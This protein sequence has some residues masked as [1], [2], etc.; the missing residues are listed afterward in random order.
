MMTFSATL[1]VYGC[2]TQEEQIG[3][4]SYRS[5]SPF[6][7]KFISWSLCC[8]NLP[9]RTNTCISRSMLCVLQKILKY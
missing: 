2:L 6:S 1:R 4:F 5:R 3:R 8:M 7:C 9:Q